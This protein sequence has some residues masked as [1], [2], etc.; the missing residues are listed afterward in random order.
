MI[1]DL[2]KRYDRRVPR[3]TSYPTAPHFS[4]AVTADD[5]QQWLSELESKAP[6]SLYLH[7]PYCREMCWYCGCNTRATK[8]HGPIAEY[9]QRLLAEIDL[10]AGA[11]PDKMTASHIHFGGGSPNMLTPDEF[12]A[13][14]ARLKR[15]FALTEKAEIA[16]EVDPRT[17]TD[18]FIDA[19][20]VAG[21]TRLSL[22][23]QDLNPAVQKAVNRI[24]PFETIA[25]IADRA[26]DQGVTDIN[27][28]LMYGL[29]AQTAENILDT[30]DKTLTLEPT[31]IAL[32]GYAHV[33]WM[34][35][36]MRLIDDKA[37][38]DAEAR[39]KQ[40]KYA[41]SQ[42]SA[43]GYV[44]IG[45]DH[46]ARPD[47]PLAQAAAA[48]TL[49]RNFQGYTTDEATILL[50]F[51]ASSIGQTPR[52]YVQN[53]ADVRRWSAAIDLGAFPTAKGCETNADDHMRRDIIERLMCDM[54]VDAEAVAI[55]H[56]F[57]L[58]D[59]LSSLAALTPM[60]ADGLVVVEGPKVTMTAA[61]EP[62][63]RAA[64]AAFDRYLA[65]DDAQAPRHARAV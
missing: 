29:P 25:R 12:S 52:G 1:A 10:V 8:R 65:A 58:S 28:D 50:G 41:K 31:R 36:H 17:T 60:V 4:A 15:H 5:Y 20:A 27:V 42:L 39:W 47:T 14:I 11:L 34:K 62:L 37:L 63:V 43:H 24:Q 3:Y 57:E 48:K 64:A 22:G 9:H 19:C 2:I 32:F 33:P 59:I 49:R 23:V 7:I 35:P 40:A 38:P 18:A 16:V 21:V 55:Q 46:F 44:P 54:K 26:K 6:V 45:M 30:I 61:G 13:V 53:D 51:G 56:G